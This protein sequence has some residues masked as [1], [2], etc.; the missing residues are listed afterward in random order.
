MDW[1]IGNIILKLLKRIYHSKSKRKILSYDCR[2][3]SFEHVI[4]TFNAHKIYWPINRYNFYFTY[5][6]EKSNSN[7][8]KCKCVVWMRLFGVMRAKHS[9][10]NSM[11]VKDAFTSVKVVIYIVKTPPKEKD[12]D[13]CFKGHGVNNFHGH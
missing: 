4:P 9:G 11:S 10:W 12:G 6:N 2:I 5:K 8:I 7:T 1:K 13:R 3:T